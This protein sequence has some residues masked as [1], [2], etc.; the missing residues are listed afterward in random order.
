[1]RNI[2]QEI[3]EALKEA[4]SKDH[5]TFEVPCNWRYLAEIAL[6]KKAPVELGLTPEEYGLLFDV[7][8]TEIPTCYEFAAVNNLIEELR[9]DDIGCEMGEYIDYHVMVNRLAKQWNE[10]TNG[11]KEAVVLEIQSK[12]ATN[13]NLKAVPE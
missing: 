3:N 1:M 9:I 12:Y 7:V 11:I 2:P 10:Q 13:Q 5:V 6:R 4:F 8:R